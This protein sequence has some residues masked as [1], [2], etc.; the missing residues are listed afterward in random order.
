MFHNRIVI[1][2][3]L[4]RDI[5]TS[6]H[7]AHGGTGAMTS[8]A[9][10]TVFW[11]GIS[12]DIEHARKTCRPCNRNAPSQSCLEPVPP[13]FPTTPFEALVADY[14]EFKGFY[15]LVIADRLSAWAYHA[16]AAHSS[17]PNRT[18]GSS[19]VRSTASVELGSAQ[20][21]QGGDGTGPPG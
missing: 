7:A 11:P 18:G 17:D 8:I 19:P 3:S 1:P 5:L 12:L 6:L 4:R 21:R 20:C 14:F 15:Y 13:I 9:Q 2:P 10:N 16:R